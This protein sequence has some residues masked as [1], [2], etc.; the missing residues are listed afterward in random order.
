MRHLIEH[1]SDGLVLAGTTGEGSTL[2]DREKIRI[3]ALGVAE[4]RGEA[5]VIAGTGSN[6]TAHSVHLTEQAT[7]LGVDAVLVVTPYYN[8]PNRRGLIAHFRAVAEATDRPVIVYN[9][10]SRCVIDLPNDLLRELAQIPNVTAV[11][12]A[13]FDDMEPI[14]GLDLLAGNDEVLAEVLD[15]GGT[16]GILVA[17]H[18]VGEEMRRM[19]DEPEER[20]SIRGAISGVV[21]AMSITSNPIP[22]KAALNLLGHRVGAPRLPLVPAAD[23][24]VDRIRA[25]L[26]QH[27]LLSAV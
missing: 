13:R 5:R 24:E 16:G 26:E 12:Q 3:W 22:V 11:K 4:C 10:P 17:S 27:G 9:I 18:L 20:E 23:E 6:D 21:E 2:S 15:M 8:K 14:D 7:E 1:G 25:A 19:I